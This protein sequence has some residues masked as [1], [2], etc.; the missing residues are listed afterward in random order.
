MTQDENLSR[1]HSGSNSD[2]LKKNVTK[3]I[4]AWNSHFLNIYKAVVAE[5]G[6]RKGKSVVI[7][8]M[9]RRDL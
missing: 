6:Q 8:V 5:S 4:V 9:T 3:I 2:F 7:L 1:C